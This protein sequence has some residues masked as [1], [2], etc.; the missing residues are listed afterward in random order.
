MSHFTVIVI[1]PDH[2][3]QLQPFHEFECTGE[4]DQYVVDVDVTE[5]SKKE[6]LGYHGLEDCIVM[7]EKDV[8]R[9]GTHKFGYALVDCDGNLI[10]AVNRTNPNNKWDWYQVGGR[11]SGFF[12]LKDGTVSDSCRFGD[13]DFEGMRNQAEKKARARYAQFHE[14]VG[15]APQPDT[16]E[17][18]QAR[19]TDRDDACKE[20][21][22]QPAMKRLQD[23]REFAFISGDEVTSFYGPV[24][25]IVESVRMNACVPFAVLKDG[26]WHERGEMGWFAFVSDEKPREAWA[27]QV[28]QI[29]QGLPADTLLTSVDC[30]I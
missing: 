9:E 22:Q 8:D 28:N 7:D 14:V 21:W 25:S 4:N 5:E 3:A 16:F 11:W 2:E 6:G 26:V 29:F 15:D 23:S 18:V 12:L 13:I 1:G 10:K 17:V 20:Y 27:A 19:N 30:H 24:E